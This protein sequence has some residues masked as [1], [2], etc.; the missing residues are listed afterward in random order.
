MNLSQQ[1]VINPKL[2]KI[3]AAIIVGVSISTLLSW[4]PV[5]VPGV[6]LVP[7]YLLGGVGLIAGG[8]IYQWV[9]PLMGTSG[10]GCEGNC[11]CS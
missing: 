2:V 3:L 4:T 6:G 5:S 9:P 11:G 1:P 7:G 10:C 8:A